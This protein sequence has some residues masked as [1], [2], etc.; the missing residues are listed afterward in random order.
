[1]YALLICSVFTQ[2]L[3]FSTSLKDLL[4]IFI[5]HS[6]EETRIYT[7]FPLFSVCI[8]Q[9]LV[10][11]SCCLYPFVLIKKSTLEFIV[12]SIININLK[13]IIAPRLNLLIRLMFQKP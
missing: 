10:N 2:F 9:K 12:K 3:K 6:S 4:P 5:L 7:V 11:I 8:C 1:M 13:M